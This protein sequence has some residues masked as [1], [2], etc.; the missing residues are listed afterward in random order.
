MLV[1]CWLVGWGIH[2]IHVKPF[3]VLRVDSKC[4]K[5]HASAGFLGKH[6][7]KIA[8]DLHKDSSG[9]RN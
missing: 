8:W 6:G 7:N 2:V 4:W 5:C 9:G 1:G 3:E